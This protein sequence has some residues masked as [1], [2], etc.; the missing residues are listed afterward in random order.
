MSAFS[1][2][3]PNGKYVAKLYFAETYAGITAPGQRVFSYNVMGHEFK[4]FDIWVKA[5]GPNRAYIETVPVEVTN[6]EFRIVFT[7]KVENPAIK[8][9]EIIPQ[10]EAGAGAANSA[11]TVRI[12]AGVSAPFTDSSGQ[13]WQA[14]TGFDCISFYFFVHKEMR[15][16]PACNLWLVR[17]AYHLPFC[18][19]LF[20]NATYLFCRFTGN[21][22]IYFVKDERGQVNRFCNKRFD[23]KH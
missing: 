21:T 4:D 14:D 8:A 5:G 20:H 16:G 9:I 19:K 12:N 23:T 17:N 11:A 2:E 10:A 13:V 18:R 22:G 6:G 3:I 15:V 7:A 1:C